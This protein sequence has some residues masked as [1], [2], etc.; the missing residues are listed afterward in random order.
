MAD[1]ADYIRRGFV[2][3]RRSL[4]VVSFILFF[5]R[6]AGLRIDEIN[7]FGNKVS[8]D[9]PWW[10]AFALWVLWVYFL[11]RFY[12]Y[13]RSISDK[14][15]W[16]AYEEQMKKLVTRS[17]LKQFKKD[18]S[19]EKGSKYE[20]YEIRDHSFPMTH[21]KYWT[22]KFEVPITQKDET[23]T[24]TAFSQRHEEDF[25]STE[26]LWIKMRAAMHVLA[27]THVATEY[28]LPF[29]LALLPLLPKL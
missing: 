15:F 12:Q 4:L 7:V 13:F 14:G 29:L 11:L 3:E 23:G 22:V 18:F 16:T 2:A 19:T 25:T 27:S 21:P 1:D 28:F 6:Q 10:T 20:F 9:S 26:L 17:A 24:I 5:Y 8:L